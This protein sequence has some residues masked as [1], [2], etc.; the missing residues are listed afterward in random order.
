MKLRAAG[1][2]LKLQDIYY[3]FNPRICIQMTRLA[4]DKG[5]DPIYC[6]YLVVTE[7]GFSSITGT[8]DFLTGAAV[9][10]CK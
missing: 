6:A 3:S 7:M 4:N 1:K 10:G 9:G 2:T 8:G 5:F